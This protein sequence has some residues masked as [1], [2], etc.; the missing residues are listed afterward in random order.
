MLTLALSASTGEEFRLKITGAEFRLQ[1]A[2]EDV[3]SL[4]LLL[5]M[6]P[7]LVVVHYGFDAGV[8]SVG[9]A[10]VASALATPVASAAVGA[11][12]TAPCS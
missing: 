11:T 6:L 7:P 3:R 4:L 2:G 10:S 12:V 8:A 9:A 5:P 1:I